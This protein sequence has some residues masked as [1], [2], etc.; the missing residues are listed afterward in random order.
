ME[1]LPR[2]TSDGQMGLAALDDLVQA[3]RFSG[4]GLP[5]A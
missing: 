3:A 2:A 5:T 4:R 1:R